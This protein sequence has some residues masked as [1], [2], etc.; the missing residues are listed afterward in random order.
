MKRFLIPILLI[1][2]SASCAPEHPAPTAT[3]A[4]SITQTRTRPP[5][6]TP[7][8][9]PTITSTP[10]ITPTP[11]PWP[12]ITPSGEL[13]THT[14]AAEPVLI[15]L[16]TWGG[17]GAQ[18]PFPPDLVLY[19]N[20]QLFI[21]N[22]NYL[23]G[24]LFT[25]QLSRQ[26]ICA[27]LNTIDQIGF[28]EYDHST[29]NYEYFIGSGG[30]ITDLAVN[31]WQTNSFEIGDLFGIVE[32]YQETS[33]E[34]SASLVISKTMY[35]FL[36]SYIPETLQPYNPKEIEIWFYPPLHEPESITPWPSDLPSLTDLYEQ[37]EPLFGFGIE[38]IR[39]LRLDIETGNQIA[40]AHTYL[41]DRFYR[42]GDTILKVIVSKLLPFTLP[43]LDPTSPGLYLDD[44][45]PQTNITCY[46]EDG[47]LAI[48]EP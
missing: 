29:N 2:L 36:S 38:G 5:T 9:S 43:D 1:L 19:S 3:L 18:F 17:D 12:T 34:P 45:P 47:L 46:P 21:Q 44:S 11:T 7:T 41:P 39:S 6:I 48:P 8:L 14:W 13:T 22:F 25:T 20:G 30:P 16:N 15:Y 33:V 40:Q 32:G 24:V 35:I 27:L 23:P 31:A 37:A 4:P 28:F 42:D 10:T 26:E